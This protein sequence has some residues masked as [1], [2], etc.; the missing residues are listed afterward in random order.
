MR[1]TDV[2]GQRFGSIIR[3]T[4]ACA[5]NSFGFPQLLLLLRDHP[6]VCGEQAVTPETVKVWAGSPP[7]VRGTVV[8]TTLYKIEQRITPAC[9]GNRSFQLWACTRYSDHPRVCGEQ[10]VPNRQGTPRIGSPPR[11]RGTG[12]HFFF[13]HVKR[14][15]TPACAGNRARG[16]E[17]PGRLGDHPRVCGEQEMGKIE[18]PVE[19]GSPPRVRGTV[20]SAASRYA[21]ARITPACAGN[22]AH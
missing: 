2:S 1:G 3:I 5:G 15:I 16:A 17:P 11:V 14:G 10:T 6:R 13:R 7:R 22:S 4:P 21:D 8:Q 18:A 12:E 9:A 19:K 20:S